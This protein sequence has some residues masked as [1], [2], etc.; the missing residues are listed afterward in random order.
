M[1]FLLLDLMEAVSFYGAGFEVDR[2]TWATIN[3]CFFVCLLFFRSTRDRS[4]QL[5]IGVMFK[6]HLSNVLCAVAVALTGS[7]RG[8]LTHP[9]A[10]YLFVRSSTILLLVYF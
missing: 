2:V 10:S 3:K 1:Q 7:A 6:E 5:I 9:L 4:S 8:I